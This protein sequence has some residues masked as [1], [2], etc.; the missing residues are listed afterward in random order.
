MNTIKDMCMSIQGY[1]EVNELVRNIVGLREW[2]IDVEP[3]DAYKHD[4]NGHLGGMN[5]TIQWTNG[6]KTRFCIRLNEDY[7]YDVQINNM[8][9]YKSV[10]LSVERSVQREQLLSVLVAMYAEIEMQTADFLNNHRFVLS[11]ETRKILNDLNNP[12]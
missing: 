2:L 9:N 6:S 8:E 5:F 12:Y 7:T 4:T 10:L 3:V 1:E 11:K